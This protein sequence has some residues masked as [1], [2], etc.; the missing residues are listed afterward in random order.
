[1]G[2]NGSP[3]LSRLWTRV[4]IVLRRVGDPV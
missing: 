1:V 2:K 3:I 4:Y